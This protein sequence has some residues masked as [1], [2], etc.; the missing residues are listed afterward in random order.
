[1]GHVMVSEH[2]RLACGLEQVEELAEVQILLRGSDVH[3]LGKVVLRV[4]T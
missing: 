1:M 4:M 3:H 2:K